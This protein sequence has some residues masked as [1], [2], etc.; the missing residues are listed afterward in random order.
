MSISKKALLSLIIAGALFIGFL[1]GL[2]YFDN[3]KEALGN[4]DVGSELTATTT[5]NGAGYPTAVNTYTATTSPKTGMIGT[6]IFTT[7]TTA[8]MQIYDATTT[9][10]ALR[11]GA[12]ASS[13]LLI[14]DFPAGTGTSTVELNAKF[15]YGMTVVW[16]GT[17]STSTITYRVNN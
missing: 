6:V 13:S 2:T 1:V 8:R 9:N 3:A 4:V 10:S 7:P 16:V 17:P 5:G 12:I 11:T 14:V 15:R